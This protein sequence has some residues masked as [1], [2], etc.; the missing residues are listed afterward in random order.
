MDE[1]CIGKLP[2]FQLIDRTQIFLRTT[3]VE[4]LIAEDHPV[5]A[6]WMFLDRL[7]LSRF[8][9][10]QRAVEGSVGR[11]AISPQLLLSIWIYSYARGVSSARQISRE[12]EHEPGLQW[13]AGMEVVNHHTLSDFRVVHGSA[14]QNLMEQVLGVLFSEGLVGLERVT[15]DGTKIRAQASKRS[16]LDR[17]HLQQCLDLAKHHIARV[18]AENIDQLSQHQ[19]AARCRVQRERET[20]L[21]SALQS[22]NTIEQL[23][24]HSDVKPA[25]VSISDPDARFMRQGDGAIAPS[26]NIQ[27]TTDT[28]QGLVVGVAVSQASNDAKELPLAMDRFQQQYGSYPAQVVADGDFTNHESVI[29]M[30]KRDIE[31]FG[32]FGERRLRR[33][34]AKGGGVYRAE[35]FTHDAKADQM[36]CPEN[37][38]LRFQYFDRQPGRTI[39]VY[40]ARKEECHVCPS[41]QACCGQ[42]ELKQTGRKITVPEDQVPIR[43]FDERMSTA[44]AKQIYRQR[45]R[46]AEFPHAWIKS[47]CGLRQFRCRTRSKVACEVLFAALTYN[48]QRYMKL[49]SFIN[50]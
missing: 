26:Y 16:F 9:E 48:L 27:F 21:Q 37:K 2:R 6:I 50:R 33:P 45:A 28:T 22:L 12:M 20:K 3:D 36:I 23:K 31:F 13:L 15:Q 38:R 17:K 10:E 1:T 42:S 47:K 25:H 29:A 32:S 8:S 44:H 34:K 39:R 43:T 7:D 46:V 24:K 4:S 11:S 30:H 49:S 41:R 5:R 35:L 19:E 40:I 18:D 14:L